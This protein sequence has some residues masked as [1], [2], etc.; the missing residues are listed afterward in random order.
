MA[1]VQAAEHPG[2]WAIWGG[3]LRDG[4]HTVRVGG[5]RL[6]GVMLAFHL[7]TLL[8]AFPLITW[9][10]RE[11]LRAS[12]MRALD[13]AALSIGGGTVLTLGLIVLICAL[14]LW[15]VS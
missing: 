5:S 1:S 8:L 13:L 10:F 7:A 15:L 2:G 12:G 11:A 14:A 9:V 4:L 3:L 6:L